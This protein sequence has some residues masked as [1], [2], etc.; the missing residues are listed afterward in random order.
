MAMD[1]NRNAPVVLELDVFTRAGLT[2]LWNLH[3]NIDRWS[4][5]NPHIERANLRG[6]LRVGATVDQLTAGLEIT[7]AIGE[8]VPQ[9]HIA[10]G[11]RT[12]GTDGPHVWTFT[13]R[14][15]D[16]LVRTGESMAG[17]RAGEGGRSWAGEPVR[18]DPRTALESFRRDWLV[19]L[20]R[21]RKIK[22]L[23]QEGSA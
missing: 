13:P 19:G 12:H 6:P 20:K 10:W 5:G 21:T 17:K 11:G 9:R 1:V 8:P 22:D 16:G 3:T 23:R 2:T 4:G 18:A 15:E 14:P 7:S